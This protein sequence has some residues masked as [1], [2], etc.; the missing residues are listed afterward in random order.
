MYHIFFFFFPE[1]VINSIYYLDFIYIYINSS[2][3]FT[4][5]SIY[6]PPLTTQCLLKWLAHSSNMLLSIPNPF[7]SQCQCFGSQTLPYRKFS[8]CERICNKLGLPEWLS[9]IR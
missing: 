9:P 1:E 8:A 7:N 6:F 4:C 3:I 5:F 2:F